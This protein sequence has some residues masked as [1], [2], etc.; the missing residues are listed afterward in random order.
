MSALPE[1]LSSATE[2]DFVRHGQ[3]IY[4]RL[5]RKALEAEHTGRF[6]AIEP[7]SGRYFLGDTGT[8]A[9]VEAHATIPD[10]TFYLVRIGYQAADTLSGY[11]GRIR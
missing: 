7:G 2:D 5:L 11:G 3:E 9:L 10:R 4:D 6:V 1:A 8:A